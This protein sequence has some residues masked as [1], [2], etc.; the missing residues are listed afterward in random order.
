MGLHRSAVLAPLEGVLG[1]RRPARP[2]EARSLERRR[3]GRRV[4]PDQPAARCRAAAADQPV[5]V[6]ADDAPVHEPAVP[7]GRGHPR[8]RRAASGGQAHDRTRSP[9]RCAP[10]T[11]PPTSSTGTRSGAASAHALELIS[12]VPL[13]E[14]RQRAYDGF[15]AERGR[16]LERWSTWCALAEAHGPDWRDWPAELAD[17]PAP[18][19]VVAADAE[20]R[21]RPRSSTPGFSG[22]PTSSLRL[23]RTRRR[24]R[25]WRTAS[26][27][28][29]PSARI[30]A[31]PTRGRISGCW[32]PGFSVGAP[33]DGF[34][35]L[36]QD[37]SQP[38]WNPRALADA[39][40]PADGRAVRRGA[41][42]RRRPP[43]RSRAW[44]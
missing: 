42:P 22:T 3:A 16:D 14:S 6:S 2:G 37:W 43:R 32:R 8:I 1:P 41:A 33:P 19:D 17:P 21:G 11:A 15:R 40:L 38:P 44:D 25:A 13:T 7:P 18:R 4:R 28:T 31:A 26:S 10:P 34:N 24:R 20:A 29:W 36:G 12:K 35:Q 30:P 23:R 5:A 39:R 9:R 27:M